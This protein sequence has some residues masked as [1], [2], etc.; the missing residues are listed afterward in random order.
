MKGLV[1]R[2]FTILSV[3]IPDILVYLLITIQRKFI[4]TPNYV[5]TF[6]LHEHFAME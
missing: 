3:D 4:A 2:R 1:L 5:C 6:V